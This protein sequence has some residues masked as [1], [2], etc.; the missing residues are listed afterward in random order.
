MDLSSW[1]LNNRRLVYFLAAVL[2][3]GGIKA[4]YNMSKLED[5]EIKVKQAMVVVTYPGASAYEVELEV[6]EVMERA[7]RA[8][9]GVEYVTTR[10]IDNLMLMEVSLEKTVPDDRV[11][12]IWDILRRKVN[13][14]RSSLPEGVMTV[15]VRDDFGDM[16]GLFYAM[17]S[18]GFSDKELNDYA[19][20]VQRE[21]RSVP[22]VGKV[23]IYGQRDECIRIDVMQERMAQLGVH[24]LDVFSTLSGQNETVY[25]GY[26]NSGDYR[27]RVTVDDRYRTAEDIGNLL[28]QGHERDQLRLRDIATVTTS[29]ETPV[30]NELIYDGQHAF[31]IL[32]AAEN[33]TDITKVGRRVEQTIQRLQAGPVPAGIA[34]HK[35]FF[36]S[37]RVVSALTTFMVNLVESIL[38]VIVVLM[39]TMGFRS[40]LIIGA[41]LLIIV[42]GSFFVLNYFHGTLQRV[43]LG[44]FI[45]AMG[46]LVDNAIVIVDGIL[47]DLQQGKPRHEALVAIGKKTSLALLGATLIAIL[48]FFPIF[49]SPDTAGVYVRDLF[50]VLAVSLML[51]WVLAMVLVPLQ[52]D[53]QLHVRPVTPDS[54]QTDVYDTK[55]YRTLRSVL[56]WVLAHRVMAVLVAMVLVLS[57]VFCY[58]FIPQGFFP[59]MDYDQCYI[60][61]KLPEVYNSTRVRADLTEISD[62]LRSRKDVAHVTISTGGTPGRY[63]LVRSIA[64]PSLAYGE[65]IVDFVSSKALVAAME[66]IQNELSGRYPEAYVR[67]KRYNLMYKKYPIELQFQGPDPAVLKQL[68]DQAMDIM[69]Q[70]THTRLVC[71][72]WENEVPML[73][74]NYSQPIARGL[75][76]SRSDL[77]TSLLSATE[78]IP[79][80]T[81]YNGRHRQTIYLQSVDEDGRPLSDLENASVFGMMPPLQNLTKEVMTGLMTGTLKEEDLL[82]GALRTIPLSQVTN[83]ISFTWQDPIV[84]RYNGERAMRAQ[85]EPAA[86]VSTEVAR[87]SLDKQIAAMA[88]PA[89]YSYTWEGEYSASHQSTQYLFKNFPLAI[90]L[91][92]MILILLFKD[93]RKPIIIFCCIPLLFVGVVY[94]MLLSGKTFGFV[95]I[96]GVLGLIGMIIKNGIILM[97]EINLQLAQGTEPVTALLN[98]SSSRFRPVMM[99]SMT[100][101]LGMIPLLTDDL[102]GSLAVTIMGG[103][104]VGTLITLL[105]IP[106]LYALFFH[107]KTGKK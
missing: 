49:L 2:V 70:D 41:N 54:G 21:L 36:Q 46:M 1:A 7:V 100:T 20:L 14:V 78:G 105:F 86:G 102:F 104:L 38:I 71:S 50:I 96:V 69:R 84:I 56:G 40:G 66:D 22:G 39:F 76:L 11:E 73:E 89:G 30:R 16:Y 42:L 37:E 57:S 60:E 106:V 91:I 55:A 53:R 18:D 34:F 87:Q 90:I 64:T 12:Q 80:G 29:Y 5:P 95:A 15:D 107:I 35:V 94:G 85:C 27:V 98:S 67:I 103:L 59:D 81:F 26:Y 24:P 3:V 99:A 33:G 101:I 9:S 47:V 63:N 44:S 45:L 68:T 28:L 23:Q 93:Y 17:T 52:A 25:S 31:G 43:S 32:V 72:D 82:A 8:M 74:V 75:G 88:L 77:G 19:E 79:T 10:S 4:F 6:A 61:Y 92:V 62:W 51:S 97:D 48:A 58:R 13:D 65:L 83:G